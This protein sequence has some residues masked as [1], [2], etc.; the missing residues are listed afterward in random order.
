MLEPLK[1]LLVQ[2]SIQRADPGFQMRVG[3]QHLP[4]MHRPWVPVP[5]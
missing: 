1:H 3:V 5:L 2:D 4:S